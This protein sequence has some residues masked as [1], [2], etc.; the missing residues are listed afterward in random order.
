[1]RDNPDID[2]RTIAWDAVRRYGF[3]PRFPD[4]VIREVEAI[5]PALPPSRYGN[6]R[7]LRS[8]LWSSIDNSDSLDLD[9]LEFCERGPDGG[10]RVQVA[11]ADVDIFVPKDSHTDR[12]AARNGTSVYTGIVKFPMLPDRLSH[13]VTS[14]VPG[15]ERYA[16]VIEFTVL[17]D[18]STRPGEIYPAIVIN[19]AKL[20]YEEV[21]V[22]QQGGG[23]VPA[24]VRA[25]PGL[26]EQ[27]HLQDE[28]SRRLK[29][30]RTEQG[31]LTFDTIEARA[32]L[33]E[34]R[35]RDLVVQRRNR[36]RCIIEEFM[37]AANGT[38]VGFLGEAGVPMI[39]RVVRVPRNWER[40]VLIAAEHGETLPRGPDAPALARFLVRQK[41]ADPDHFPDL[42][43]AVIKLLGPGE[44]APLAP[45]QPSTGHFSLAVS[46][47]TH[48][49]A[50]NR[51]YVDLVNQRL[52]KAVLRGGHPPYTLEELEDLAAWLTDRDKASTKVERFMRKAAAGMLLRER[53]GDT[54]DAFVTGVTIHGTFV[55]LI[56]PPA[57]G[58][59]VRGEK[60]MDVGDKVRV[61]LLRTDPAN[62]HIDFEGSR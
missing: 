8:L 37:V 54:F 25:I 17:P 3:E 46:D 4:N 40:I 14:L 13:D 22:W 53:I 49:T 1:M 48:A 2:L 10:I 55:R 5:N 33:E 11:I 18:G 19:K 35:V 16:M 9:Q 60:G 28:A 58:K 43:L 62:G 47:Y 29:K 36:A 52:L 51:R 27:V 56:S 57:E 59:V 26:E 23:E 34:G 42:S 15:K 31:A 21:A 12:H 20:V 6:M 41:A 44:Y 61:R 45:G 38:L 30:A 24:G 32:V 50:P 7:D 39:Q